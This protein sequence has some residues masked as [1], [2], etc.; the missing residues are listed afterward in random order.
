MNQMNRDNPINLYNKYTVHIDSLTDSYDFSSDIELHFSLDEDLI[1]SSSSS[2]VLNFEHLLNNHE[3][4]S[5]VIST[6]FELS[7]MKD[8]KH[9]EFLL[10]LCS[11]INSSNFCTDMMISVNADCTLAELKSNE[12]N[13]L[14]IKT[15]FKHILD[16][17]PNVKIGIENTSPFSNFDEFNF[18]NGCFSSYTD[19]VFEF[20]KELNTERIGS[21]LNISNAIITSKVFELFNSVERFKNSNTLEHFYK[22]NERICFLV[23][24]SNSNGL[25]LTNNSYNTN[26]NDPVCLNS[27]CYSTVNCFKI[28]VESKNCTIETFENAL[29]LYDKYLRSSP[30]SIDYNKNLAS[31]KRT[32][33]MVKLFLSNLI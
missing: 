17:Y 18:S 22:S 6:S 7:D 28:F 16:L 1:E 11:V 24:L 2:E 31:L 25:G 9:Q 5:I 4:S 12:N 14:E 26:F 13:L 23:K 32:I 33:E 20:R 21:V 30:I 10:E 8:K 15:F 19:M 3:L 29:V 27:S